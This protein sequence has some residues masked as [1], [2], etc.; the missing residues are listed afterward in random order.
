MILNPAQNKALEA[1]E[2]PLLTIAGPGTGKTQ[3]LSARVGS[4]LEKTD[5]LPENILCLTFTDAASVA[6]RKRLIKFMGVAAHRVPIFTFHSFSQKVISDYQN[7]LGIQSLEPVS[8][9]EAIVYYN[10][11]IDSF[12]LG[13]PLKNY[14]FPY[15]YR[16]KLIKLNRLLKQ[17]R[18]TKDSLFAIIDKQ[19]EELPYS[20]KVIYKRAYKG[21]KAGDLNKINYN[22]ELEK[23][24]K[25]KVATQA[26]YDYRKQLSENGRYDFDDMILWVTDFLKTNEYAL[27][28]YQEQYQYIMVDEY[29]DTNKAQNDLMLILASYW[30]NPNLMVVGDDD[31]SIYR[32]QGANVEN[33]H[34]FESR[35]AKHLQK[36]VLSENYRS[37]QAI[38]DSAS[39]VI[40]KNT[41]R[42]IADKKLIEK[43]KTLLNTDAPIVIEC[44]NPL[45]ETAFIVNKIIEAHA[46]GLPYSEIA[47]IY[48][49]H[50]QVNFLTMYLSSKNIPFYLKKR[51][52][53][54]GMPFIANII[55]LLYYIKDEKSKPYSGE[56]RL[57]KILHYDFWEIAP[58]DLA[59]LAFYIKQEK[60]VWRD[61]I[62]GISNNPITNHQSPIT[63]HQSPITNHQFYKH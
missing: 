44:T 41:T 39:W 26:C 30:E 35:F 63:N 5:L 9:L 58:A 51:T 2:G 18:L 60:I 16:D 40:N 38:L 50:A 46:N 33:L 37:S 14:K 25:L 53:I 34:D 24:N 22:K 28:R 15:V 45:Y 54:L 55:E 31:Q 42:L 12:E 43:S 6:M 49:N 32:F 11:I 10:K 47:V 52:N 21:N 48:R 23:L 62:N 1:I 29:Q 3:L 19:I 8:D 4:I 27:F 17:E 56:H 57:F 36:V 20:E 59:K 7:E 61:A 13:N